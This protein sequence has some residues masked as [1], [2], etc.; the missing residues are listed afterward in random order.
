MHPGYRNSVEMVNFDNEELLDTESEVAAG[1]IGGPPPTLDDL[2]EKSSMGAQ[3]QC[4]EEEIR[5]ASWFLVDTP[6]KWTPGEAFHWF[7]QMSYHVVVLCRHKKNGVRFKVGYQ[8]ENL[9][10]DLNRKFNYE[11]DFVSEFLFAIRPKWERNGKL[12]ARFQVL[13]TQDPTDLNERP[14]KHQDP[15]TGMYWLRVRAVQGGSKGDVIDHPA[16]SLKDA[17]FPRLL[18][19]GTV[20]KAISGISRTGLCRAISSV[21]VAGTRCISL[22]LTPPPISVG[23]PLRYFERS[24]SSE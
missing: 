21:K 20:E 14:L 18:A 15:E 24:I 10:D 23:N 6:N 9:L 13:G 22:G 4:P 3:P 2:V 12:K 8:V 11:V 7:Q 1:D 19:H 16:L 5:G 17:N